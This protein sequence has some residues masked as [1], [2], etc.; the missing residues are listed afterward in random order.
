MLLFR[1][2]DYL[3][4]IFYKIIGKALFKNFGAG[5]RIVF[6]LRI[7]GSKYIAL[8]DNVTLQI[9]AF[10]VAI[11]IGDVSP[12]L[13]IKAG[14]LCGNHVH[15]VCSK[16]IVIGEHVLIA[17]KVY[18]SDNLHG[19]ENINL[20]VMH[21]P[22]KQI[23]TVSIGAGSWIGEN[24]SIIGASIGK[25]CVIGANSVVTKNI[26]DYSVAVGSPAVVIKQY[27]TQTLT[28]EKTDSKTN[29]L[30]NSNTS[31]N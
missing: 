25:N 16:S 4:V 28:W 18:I 8:N 2:R 10:V 22:L 1:I 3:S 29:L 9:G 11:P 19:Y 24:V 20:P 12:A 23:G 27:N 15:I 31:N 21:Q 6:P 17:D 14:T 13:E 26:P 5:V 30:A 7:I